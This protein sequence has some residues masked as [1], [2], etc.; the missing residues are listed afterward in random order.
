MNIQ[1]DDKS[2]RG[3]IHKDAS[4]DEASDIFEELKKGEG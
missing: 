1:T 3:I 2:A 4:P